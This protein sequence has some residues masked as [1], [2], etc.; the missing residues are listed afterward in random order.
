MTLVIVGG[1]IL[2]NV[3]KVY[4]VQVDVMKCVCVSQQYRGSAAALFE[5]KLK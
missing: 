5:R 3:C 1:A 2:M 4:K